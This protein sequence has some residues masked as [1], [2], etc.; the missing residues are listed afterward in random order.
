[1]KRSILL[2]T[3]L[4]ACL[5][6][7]ADETQI[8]LIKV[9]DTVTDPDYVH[10]TDKRSLSREPIATHD[11]NII[12]IYFYAPAG[13]IYITVTDAEDNIVYESKTSGDCTFTLNSNAQGMFTLTLETGTSTYEGFFYIE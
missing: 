3:A 10:R 7:W 9:E 12:H 4:F 8:P 6:I 5:F 2:L 11:G 1:M 13:S